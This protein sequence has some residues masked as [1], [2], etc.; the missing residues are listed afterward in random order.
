MSCRGA[1]RTVEGDMRGDEMHAPFARTNRRLLEGC[2]ITIR[3]STLDD[4]DAIQRLAQLDGRRPPT[5]E[6]LLAIVDGEPWAAL[7]PDGGDAIADPF[8]PTTDLVA[9][10]RVRA[11]V[12][13]AVARSPARHVRASLS[14]STADPKGEPA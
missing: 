1:V 7:S 4:G 11:A 12:H 14:T 3:L 5:G 2:E 10:L 13:N 9:L 6:L 8:R